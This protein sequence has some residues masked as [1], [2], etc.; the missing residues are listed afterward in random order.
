MAS[1]LK[2]N[3]GGIDY[4]INSDESEEYIRNISTNINGKLEEIARQ[5]PY[6]STTMVAVF[7]A[8]EYCDAAEQAKA[9]IARLEQQAKTHVEDAACARLEAEEARRE[10]ERL[11]KE[12]YALRRKLEEATGKSLF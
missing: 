3:I 4:Y 11:G 12:N 10:I 8:L 5:N 9:Q 1:K 2:L 7:A 6:L